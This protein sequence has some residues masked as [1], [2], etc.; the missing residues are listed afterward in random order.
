MVPEPDE[1]SI[2]VLLLPSKLEG[3]EREAPARGLLSIPRVIALEPSRFRTPRPLRNAVGIRQAPPPPLPGRPA[4]TSARP[5]PPRPVPA[6][7]GAALPRRRARAVV[8]PA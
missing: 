2:A 1:E 4:P 7:A 8:R 6:R 5:P 3:F